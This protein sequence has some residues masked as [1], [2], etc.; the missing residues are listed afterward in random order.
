MFCVLAMNR[1]T[2]NAAFFGPYETEADAGAA[3]IRGGGVAG[4]S[5]GLPSPCTHRPRVAIRTARLWCASV[6]LT[7]TLQCTSAVIGTC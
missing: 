4:M 6:T 2:G 5:D 3:A 1:K 7:A